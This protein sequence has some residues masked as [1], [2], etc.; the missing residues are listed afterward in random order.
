MTMHV[1][2]VHAAAVHAPLVLLPAAAA[3][4]LAAALTG[5]RRQAALG[6]RLWWLEVGAAAFAGVA[7]LAAS[8]EIK[9]EDPDTR[10]MLWLHGVGN[11]AGLLGGVGL[12]VWRSFRGP[13]VGQALLGLAAGGVSFFTAYLGGELVYGRGVGVRAQPAL[14]ANGVRRSPRLLSAAAPGVP[15]RRGRG[16]GVAVPPRPRRGS[17]PPAARRG[18]RRASSAI[19]RAMIPA[20]AT[21]SA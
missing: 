2:E 1:H 5:D 3:V 20:S 13:S 9:A 16:A 14:A 21:A 17:P 6:R 18:H 4:D 7:G 15:A 11:V 19:D 8:Q 12:A 10:D